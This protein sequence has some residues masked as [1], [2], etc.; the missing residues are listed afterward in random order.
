MVLQRDDRE[1]VIALR[2]AGVYL[3]VPRGTWH[4]ART[5]KPSTLLFIT[6]GEGT[7]H[8]PH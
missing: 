3:L 7:L 1:E 8:K 2:T 4:T 5:G 6:R